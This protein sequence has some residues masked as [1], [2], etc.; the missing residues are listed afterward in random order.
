MNLAR[1]LSFALVPVAALVVASHANVACAGSPL[2]YHHADAGYKIDILPI[3]TLK[4]GEKGSIEIVVTADAG[5][6][7]HVNE[8]YPIKFKAPDPAGDVTYDKP[9][10]AYKPGQAN[11]EFK[12][13]PCKYDPKLSCVLH[14]VVPVTPNKKGAIGYGGTVLF[15]VCDP[16]TCLNPKE[17]FSFNHDTK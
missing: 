9:V 4:A 8:E 10:I 2:G 14:I 15:G 3:G 1:K 5:N 16:K 7:F 13:E 17:S 6:S 11:P 12:F